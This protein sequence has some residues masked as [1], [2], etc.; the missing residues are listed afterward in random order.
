MEAIGAGASTLAFVL[1]AL[2]STK[3]IHESLSAIKDAPR[4]VCELAQDIQLLQSV[5]GRLTHCPLSHAPSST[6]TSFQ[7][8]LQAC[9]AELSSIENRLE[10]FKKKPDSSRSSR[11]YK[12]ILGYVKKEELEEARSRV[13]DK[14]TQANLYLGLLQ[15][16]AISDTTSKIDNQATATTGILE[17][18]LGEVARLHSRLDSNDASTSHDDA[19]EDVSASI[20]QNLETMTLCSELEESISRLSSLVDHDGL[21]LDADDAEQIIDDL[22]K[23]ILIA[24]DKVSSKQTEKGKATTNSYAVNDDSGQ[25]RRDLKLIEGLMLSAPIVAI[26]QPVPNSSHLR[27]HLPNGAI[28]KQKRAREE[29]DVEHGFLTVSVNK[30]R[31][32]SQRPSSSENT[33]THRDVVANIMFRPSASPWMFS[34][35]VSQGQLFDRSIQ[36]IPRISV[37]PIIP[38]GS[39]VFRL[40]QEGKLGEFRILLDEGKASLRDHDEQGMPLLHYAAAGSVDM[41]KFL[42]ESGADVDEMG[43]NSGTALSHI[44]GL[45]RHD[46]TLV[47]LENMAD[48]TLSYPGWDNPLSAAC[49]SDIPSVE[50]F[51]KHGSHF[52]LHDFESSDMNGRTRL[53]QICMTDSRSTS[54]RKAVGMLV[55]AGANMNARI[56]Q[57]WSPDDHQTLVFT[58]LHSLVYTAHPT[59]DRNELETLVYLIRQG[60]DPSAVDHHDNTVAMRAYLPNENDNQYSSKGSYRGDLWD[61]AV[62]ICGYDLEHFRASY[63]RVP[64]YNKSYSRQD[65]E[66]L[67]LGRESL[68]PYWDDKRYPESGGDEDYWKQPSQRCRHTSCSECDQ[69]GEGLVEAEPDPI[70]EDD[71]PMYALNYHNRYPRSPSVDQMGHISRESDLWKRTHYTPDLSPEQHAINDADPEEDY[72]DEMDLDD[73]RD[74]AELEAQYLLENSLEAYRDRQ[75]DEDE[76]LLHALWAENGHEPPSEEDGEEAFWRLTRPVE[77]QADNF[78]DYWIDHDSPRKE[79]AEESYQDCDG[80]SPPSSEDGEDVYERLTGKLTG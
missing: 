47:L 70:N 71:V 20:T 23:F 72:M 29:I 65:F 31:R 52:A 37:C 22:R 42:I 76:D 10:Q 64:R 48:P 16:Q 46:T 28:I 32:L 11:V 62:A 74:E 54:K 17:Q 69:D 26:N 73:M 80:I 41:C 7:D 78:I 59:E 15:A 9:T 66:R 75:I 63:P 14:T 34:V 1:L 24:R 79:Q 30:R 51:L 56:V 50:L 2:K 39:P 8:M 67:W 77:D 57:S 35:S 4:I 38:N 43:E 40:V 19:T 13:R 36:S 53:H 49:S 3:I 25:V 18:I 44:T 55:A 21:T 6:V 68:C 60:A 27:A 61:A 12:G 58:C 45:S 33:S 5:L